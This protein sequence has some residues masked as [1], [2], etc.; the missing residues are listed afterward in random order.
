MQLKTQQHDAVINSPIG[1]LG[2]VVVANKLVK[3]D[4]LPRQSSTLVTHNFVIQQTIKQLK[5]YFCHP[6]VR[7]KIPLC[8]A[9]TPLQQQIWQAIQRIPCGKTM[10]YGEL[11]QKIA[12]S[13]RVIGNACRCNPIPLVIPCHRVVAATDLGGYCGKGN[14]N[15]LLI[16]QWLLDFEQK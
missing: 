12:T 3:I 14:K 4:F 2:I 7:F 13:P 1:K 8:L 9:G 5:E 16:K 10:T 6:R 15:R 11:A